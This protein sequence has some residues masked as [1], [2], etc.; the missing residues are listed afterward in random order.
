MVATSSDKVRQI[1]TRLVEMRREAT[2]LRGKAKGMVA[3][4]GD[5]LPIAESDW[6]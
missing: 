4:E 6:D 1:E 3:N 5:C 2:T